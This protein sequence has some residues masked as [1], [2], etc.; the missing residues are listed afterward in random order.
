MSA[1]FV[2]R[3]DPSE[4]RVPP[5]FVSNSIEHILEFRVLGEVTGVIRTVS[6]GWCII[7]VV[8][9]AKVNTKAYGDCYNDDCET[10]RDKLGMMWKR[11]RSQ[12]DVLNDQTANAPRKREC[13]HGRKGTMNV[14]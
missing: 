5:V 1:C 3:S 4:L 14:L 11:V 6:R 10:R 8:A 12:Y 7:I 9:H 2:E 13:M